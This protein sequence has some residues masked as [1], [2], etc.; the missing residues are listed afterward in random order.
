MTSNLHAFSA[1]STPYRLSMAAV[2]AC[3]LCIAGF[4]WEGTIGFN[5]ADEGFLWYGAQRVIHGEVPIRDFQSYDIGRY[6]WAAMIMWLR[7][8]TGLVSLWLSVAIFQAIGLFLALAALVRSVDRVN[9]AWLIL[10]AVILWIWMIPRHKIFDITISIFL[11]TALAWLI[12]KPNSSRFFLAGISIGLAA[13]FNRNHGVYGLLGHIGVMTLLYSQNRQTLHPLSKI[14]SWLAGIAV[15]FLPVGLLMMFYSG[16]ADA[17][18]EGIRFMMNIMVKSKN[19]NL[20]L[21][22][23]WPWRET[24]EMSHWL[25]SLRAVFLGVLFVGILLFGAL[26]VATAFYRRNKNTQKSPLFVASAFMTLPYAHH[27][28]SRAEILHLAQGL[29]PVLLGV[30]VWA[31]S[32]GSKTKWSVGA[33]MLCVSL[34]VALP[35]HLG[36]QKSSEGNWTEV[37]LGKDT[38]EVNPGIANNIQ[39]VQDLINRY[40]QSGEAFLVT[41]YWPGVYAMAQRKSPTWE[42]YAI[43]PS[44]RSLE[45]D[46][47]ARI[48]SAHPQFA[49]IQNIPLEGREEFKFSNTH[50][51]I[52]QYISDNFKKA[53]N[54]FPDA[55]INV[56]LPLQGKP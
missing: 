36:W 15:G 23:P 51:L 3:V 14:T 2:I 8:D 46:E 10:V 22:V 30:F 13:V 33:A 37:R 42:I 38:I 25:A 18:W 28:F 32:R 24:F 6:Y 48:D 12:E 20:T 34:L 17:F 31:S 7:G 21:P 9:P 44:N 27:A 50:P 35:A 39:I 16:F 41:P 52:Y 1:D 55:T 56:Y 26:G 49:I 4:M 11:V 5:L 54:P 47:I 45:E 29:F 43:F 53:E 40:A 19:T